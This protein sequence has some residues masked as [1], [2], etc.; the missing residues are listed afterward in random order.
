MHPR[1]IHKNG[2]DFNA[3]C[4]A[5]PALTKWVVRNPSGKATI[6]FAMPD[7]V[8]LLN[9]ALLKCYYRI[10]QWDL[11]EGYLCPPVPG[12]ADY[13][14]FIADLLAEDHK[15]QTPKGSSIT[16]LDIGTGANL[17]YPIVGSQQ[18]GWRF[19]GSEVDKTAFIAAKLI[20]QSNASL[21]PLVTVRK[22]S[23]TE[24]I[25]HDVIN[26]KDYFTFTLCNPPFHSSAKAAQQGSQ[27]KNSNLQRHQQK[28][29]L[30]G[31]MPT[32][33]SSNDADVTLNFAGQNTELWCPGGEV[34][35]IKRM[36]QESSDYKTQVGW[37]TSLVSKKDSLR[38]IYKE[39]E[40][41]AVADLKTIAMGQGSKVSRFVAWRF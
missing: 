38:P 8:K 7:A 2:Y 5:E 29:A 14:H 10:S 27:R 11:P 1:N 3:L 35:F 13:V 12:R 20:A 32:K 21:K 28:R 22:Q 30:S 31:K 6:D 41:A 19:V 37:F 39:L 16:G 17:I 9:S 40:K 23:N 24:H 18:Y 25:F 26:A 33:P 4:T 15:G 36:V 34:K